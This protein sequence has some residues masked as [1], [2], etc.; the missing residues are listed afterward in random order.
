MYLTRGSLSSSVS[1]F[2]ISW[3]GMHEK[4]IAIANDV[5]SVTD[6]VSIV[7][8][9]PDPG[10]VL[11]ATCRSLRRPD[12]LFWEDKFR[13]AIDSCAE[14]PLLIIHADCS[15]DDWAELVRKCA[16]A[17]EQLGD[18]GVWAPW[19]S[20]T[21]YEPRFTAISRLEK[22]DWY[23]STLT[24]GIVFSLAPPIIRRMRQVRYG[25][26]V[27]G[28]GIDLLF[29]ASAYV[30]HLMVVMDS[31][32]RVSHPQQSGYNTE[33]AMSAMNGFLRQFTLRERLECELLRSFV[34]GRH[35]KFERMVRHGGRRG[36]F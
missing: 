29:C 23:L 9:D 15:C 8:S 1:V 36:V 17:H 34:S 33:V 12:D 7:Y 26:N 25:Q 18:L 14:G 19:I 13:T 24:N 2:I 4:A 21:Y 20:G 16:T 6:D 35:M 27:L 28:W 22:T 5:L 31:S 32:V 10:V 30:N 3:A 11:P